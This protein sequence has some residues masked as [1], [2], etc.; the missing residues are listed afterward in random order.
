M[1]HDFNH[2]STSPLA[3]L[4]RR[5]P[6]DTAVVSSPHPQPLLGCQLQLAV[7]FGTGLFPV[8]EVA[9]TTSNAAFTAIESA[10]G[11]SKIRDGR[12]LAVDGTAGV[13]ARV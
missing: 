12:E 8:N 11:F 5:S 2:G 13:P 4:R 6:G 3:R 7:K 1:A 9:E 10:A